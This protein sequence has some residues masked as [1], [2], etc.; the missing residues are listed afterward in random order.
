MWYGDKKVAK[1]MTKEQLE[2]KFIFGL[3][4]LNLGTSVLTNNGFKFKE[5]S[6][7]LHP[8]WPGLL[9]AFS[10]PTLDTVN[11]SVCNLG[12]K[13]VELLSYALF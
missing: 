11:L 7:A 2:K 5:F 9:N 13:D 1:D 10:S 3:S 4:H 12:S 6:K 8:K